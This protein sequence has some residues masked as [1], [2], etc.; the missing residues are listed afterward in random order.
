MSF[1]AKGT[2]P[3]FYITFSCH[4][5][6]ISFSLEEY[7]SLSLTFRSLANLKVT[8]HIFCFE[9][10]CLYSPNLCFSDGFFHGYAHI[11]HVWQ[12]FH[13]K[14]NLFFSLPSIRRYT[15]SICLITGDVIFDHLIKVMTVKFLPY[16]VTLFLFVVQKV[17][18]L[19]GEEAWDYVNIPFL[20]RSPIVLASI[21][22]SWMNYLLFLWL[23]SGNFQIPQFLLN[24]LVVILL[25]EKVSSFF[26]IR[27]FPFVLQKADFFL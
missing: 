9:N 5:S 27:S 25:W 20:E 19:C 2:T 8:E 24:L 10:A 23:P 7:S 22:V 21:D 14:Y 11:L 17:F 13:R 4:V 12:E 3:G 26:P 18:C 16:K 15:I 1:M 6:L